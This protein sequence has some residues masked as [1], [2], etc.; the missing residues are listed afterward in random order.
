MDEIK[1]MLGELHLDVHDIKRGVYGDPKN[2]VKGLVDLRDD[3]DSLKDSKKKT[4]WVLVGA[5]AVIEFIIH[6]A[7]FFY[8]QK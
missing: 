2:K 4:F 1:K 5:G 8:N 7:N 6:I 3:V